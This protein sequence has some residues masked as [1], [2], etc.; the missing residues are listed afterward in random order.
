MD[1][2]LHM[3]SMRMIRRVTADGRLTTD[4]IWDLAHFFNENREARETWPGNMLWPTLHSAFDDQ[5]I[6]D[7]EMATLGS[8]LSDILMEANGQED[9]GLPLTSGSRT[10]NGIATRRLSGHFFNDSNSS[11]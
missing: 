1:A 4:E 8:M 9:L 3:E 7:E 5:K 11:Q 10:G 6:D 2:H